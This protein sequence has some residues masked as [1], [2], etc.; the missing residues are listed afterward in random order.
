MGLLAEVGAY[1]DEALSQTIVDWYRFSFLL[2]LFYFFMKH[3]IKLRFRIFDL[4]DDVIHEREI[5]LIQFENSVS[6]LF[7]WFQI[8]LIVK[9][10]NF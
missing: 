6:L 4:V 2:L 1:L 5:H 3:F 9:F 7:C 8:L 10:T